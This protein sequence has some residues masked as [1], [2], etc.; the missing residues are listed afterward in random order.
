[1]RRT[2]SLAMTSVLALSA[3]VMPATAGVDKLR[4]QN[5]AAG[6][7]HAIILQNQADGKTTA[8][9]KQL[10]PDPCKNKTACR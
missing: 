5:Q 9:A 8:K 1:M 6:S 7:N 10:P 3:L 4:A 2:L